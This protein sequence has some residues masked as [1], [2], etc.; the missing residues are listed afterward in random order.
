LITIVRVA[1]VAH[2][3]EPWRSDGSSGGTT[4]LA[5]L[6]PGAADSFVGEAVGLGDRIVFNARQFPIQ[7]G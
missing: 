2:G 7:A 5:D 1:L 3:R 4:M 6:S